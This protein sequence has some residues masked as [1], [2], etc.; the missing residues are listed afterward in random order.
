VI[1]VYRRASVFEKISLPAKREAQVLPGRQK[2]ESALLIE[3]S[4]EIEHN[5]LGCP[6][7]VYHLEGQVTPKWYKWGI[8]LSEVIKLTNCWIPKIEVCE[9]DAVSWG[10]CATLVPAL[11]QVE[12]VAGTHHSTKLVRKLTT[13]FRIGAENNRAFLRS[14]PWKTFT[15]GKDGMNLRLNRRWST[16]AITSRSW[17]GCRCRTWTRWDSKVFFNTC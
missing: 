11:Y 17:R 16:N 12:S 10:N 3:R 6:L 15:S 4:S 7:L 9:S 14:T 5:F 2:C 8:R 1:L 13:D